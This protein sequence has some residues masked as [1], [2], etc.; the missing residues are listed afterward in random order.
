M[1]FA[2]NA[3]SVRLALSLFALVFGVS[4]CMAEVP[5]E[6]KSLTDKYDARVSAELGSLVKSYTGALKRLEKELTD[7][8]ELE[9]A[10]VVK[11]YRLEVALRAGKAG[12]G[13]PAEPKKL[14]ELVGVFNQEREK[15]V[16][17]LRKIYITELTKLERK[18]VDDGR[19]RD[20]I[21]VKK[22]RVAAQAE[23]PE[24]PKIVDSGPKVGTPSRV[25]EPETI[26]KLREGSLL[27]WD[28][29]NDSG[30]S[31]EDGG[32][33]RNN[34]RLEG[35]KIID[36]EKRGKVASFA[37][38]S[39]TIT[40][41]RLKKFDTEEISISLWIKSG[42]ANLNAGIFSYAI[43]GSTNELLIGYDG[44]LFFRKNTHL[45]LSNIPSKIGEWQHIVA[46]FDSNRAKAVLYVDGEEKFARDWVKPRPVGGEGIIIMG[47]DQDTFG[48]GLDP[49]QAFFGEMDDIVVMPRVLSKSEVSSLF[50]AQKRKR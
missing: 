5:D 21:A 3:P 15:K 42:A 17:P 49:K 30:R 31:V 16:G 39:D 46:T 37:K 6:L 19:L 50:R 24:K 27:W 48:G 22:A 32:A 1:F 20:A 4:A 26:R 11:E 13:A 34:G 12:D 44:V 33:N 2:M 7:A 47:Q 25:G 14:A 41:K 35:V 9:Q 36:D 18:M 43:E 28:F 40:A 45:N 29:E 8:S 10:L 23:V 38:P